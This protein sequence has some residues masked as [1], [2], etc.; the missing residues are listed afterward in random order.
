MFNHSSQFS[1]KGKNTFTHVR[2]NQVNGNV[3]TGT[4]NINTGPAVAKRTE[5]DEFQYVRRGDMI[6]TKEIHSDELSEWD[7]E[8]Q[9]GELVGRSKLSTRRICTIEIVGRESKYTAM[10]YEGEDA[11]DFLEKDF[12]LFSRNKKPGSCQLFGINQSAIPAL[13]FHH[14]LIPCAHFFNGA[15]IWMDVYIQHL[16]TNM[17]CSEDNLWM[18]TAGGVFLSGPDGPF[19][20][21]PRSNVVK[22]I[23]VP[24]TVDMLKDDTCV[25]FF[26]NFGTSVDDS[27]L[28]CARRNLEPTY[29]HDLFPA[30]AGDHQSEDSDHPNWSSATHPYLRRL[31]RNP[32]DH[33]PMNV[34]GGL[35]FDTIY[36]SSMEAVA[37]WP[38]EAGSLWEW[39]EYKR[40]GLVEGT[41]LDGGLT[42]FKLDL[43]RGKEVYFEA[44]DTWERLQKG[45]LSQ[46]SWAFNAVD[47]TEEKERFFNVDP[48]W[49]KIRSTR[50][51]TASRTLRNDEH[52]IEGTPPTSIYLF[53]CP[54]PVSVSELVSW[55]EGQPYFWSFDKTGQSRMSEEE[56]NS[57][58]LRSWSTHIYTTL[59]DWQRARGFDPATSDWARE[60][61]YPEW[62]IVG[63]RKV[64]EQKK[65]GSS[66]WQW[67]AIAESG[68]SAFG[69]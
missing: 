38:S 62:E 26:V 45:W 55:I 41:V 47:V 7:W 8:L 6:A 21:V 37:R 24:T 32:P 19:A 10:I 25:R 33:L 56:Y 58:R 67:E 28:E 30:T 35:R 31:W 14:E 1:I 53:L 61:G 34:I 5:H 9:N 42:R 64:Q 36:S 60:L 29:L 44:R 18:N 65:A 17:G 43:T 27:V 12:Q 22:S 63:T 20:P 50:H 46:S 15:S 52:L 23:V 16:R 39:Q 51:P 66:W 49:L 4:V 40:K 54:F 68:I 11:Q 13:I 3:Y 59:Q 69:F 48:P 57:V 2:G